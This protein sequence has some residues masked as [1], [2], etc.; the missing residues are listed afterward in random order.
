MDDDAKIVPLKPDSKE[1]TER[2]FKAMNEWARNAVLQDVTLVDDPSDAEKPAASGRVL[3]DAAP[4]LAR[5]AFEASIPP[6]VRRRMLQSDGIAIVVTVPSAAWV[7]P[8]AKY[9]EEITIASRYARNGSEKRDHPAEGNEAV[10]NS[11]ADGE[12]VLGISQDP[13]RFLPSLLLASADLNVTVKRP[14][15]AV[16]ARA[17]RLCL[18]GR[19]PPDLPADLGAGMDFPELIAAF[20]KNTKPVEAIRRLQAFQAAAHVDDDDGEPLPKLADAIFYGPARDW[21]LDLAVDISEAK[22]SGN[23]ESLPRGALFAGGTGT[24][25]SVLA[26]VIARSCGIPFVSASLGDLFA[27]GDGYLGGVVKASRALF[28]RAAALRPC[29]LFIDE[30]DA[31]PN[32]ATMEARAREW[33]TTVVNDFLILVANAP[34]GVIILAATNHVEHIDEALLRPG[35]L[36]RVF[37]IRS[38]ASAEA[39]ESVFRFHLQGALAGDDLL[40]LAR[41]VLGAT[42]ATVMDYIRTARRQAKTEGRAMVLQDLAHVVCPPDTRT[43]VERRRTAIH[44]AAHIVIALAVGIASVRSVSIQPKGNTEGRVAIDGIGDLVLEGREQIEAIVTVL[45]AGRAAE[46]V[47][48]GSPT[49]GAGGDPNSDLA[50]ATRFVASMY[51]SLGLAGGGA[52]FRG[53]MHEM[54]QVMAFDPELRH[55]VESHLRSLTA[56][57]EF[58]VRQHQSDIIRVADLLLEKRYLSTD[59]VRAVMAGTPRSIANP[60]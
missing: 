58:L 39:L 50:H 29:V 3:V 47:I 1:P 16:I 7:R 4:A 45:L 46:I 6:S 33:W 43:P 9:L 8:L 28:A 14:D 15:T 53:T 60:Q 56:K 10:A 55:Q 5:A 27:N 13:S 20:R 36:E 51:A 44:E 41:I 11:L 12:I 52:T 23:F 2:S 35:R 42:P 31:L 48:S 22:Q 32:R 24:G 30:L 17:M 40:P 19:V 54:S 59:E 26:K 18:R 57:T 49:G 25:K 21:A 37:Q 34:K 38:P